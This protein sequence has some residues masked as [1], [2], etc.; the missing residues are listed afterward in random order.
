MKKIVRN[1]GFGILIIA[2][3][4]FIA[5][6]IS[7]GFGGRIKGERLTR[8]QKSP[9]FKNGVFQNPIPTTVQSDEFSFWEVMREFSRKDQGRV[10]ASPIKVMP[11]D[12]SSFSKSHKGIR[13]NWLGHSSLIIE[14]DGIVIWT[15]PVFSERTSPFSFGGT[16]RF[17]YSR[18]YE[19][20]DLPEPD[21]V[22]ISHD[23]YDH[24]DRK[25][26][27][28]LKNKKAHFI[29]PLGVGAHFDRWGFTPSQYTELD[30]NSE[31][32]F[33]SN[34]NI[35]ATPA[36]HFT[37]RGLTDRNKT[38]WASWVIKTDSSSVFFSG[39]SGY[40]PGFK[41]IGEQ[42]G[43]FDLC[44]MECGQYNQNWPY[45][46]MAPEESVQAHVDLKGK[47]MLP[48]HW[49]K[50]KL[51]LHPWTEPVERALKAAEKSGCTLTTP[52]IGEQIIV[53][54]YTPQECWWKENC[55]KSGIN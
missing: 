37:G 35:T 15:D 12:K 49:G 42:H 28:K 41:T 10:P 20:D 52:Q 44:I 32:S 40:F 7:P 14:I 9:N 1:I 33:D 24:L 34:L 47:Q 16:K 30:W 51:S 13:V 54:E 46:H 18:H 29:M 31:F 55:H 36:R 27:L 53:G 17:D 11:I 3:G 21:L 48:I 22:I 6:K 43:P 2:L 8:I 19:I 38:L 4:G 39:D 45:I 50:F 23:H 5:M 26:V 25:A